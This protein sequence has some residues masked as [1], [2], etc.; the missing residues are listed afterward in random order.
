MLMLIFRKDENTSG[1]AGTSKC[2][3]LDCTWG[4]FQ[5]FTAGVER[6]N[7]IVK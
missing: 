6:G 2:F 1:P 5:R 7:N 3:F 4:Q